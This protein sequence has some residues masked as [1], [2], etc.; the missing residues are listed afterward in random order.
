[1]DLG[2]GLRAAVVRGLRGTAWALVVFDVGAPITDTGRTAGLPLFVLR[3]AAEVLSLEVATL[4]EIGVVGLEAAFSNASW[5][6][7]RFRVSCTLNI[8]SCIEER[9]RAGVPKLFDLLER[10]GLEGVVGDGNDMV[11]AV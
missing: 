5:P 8:S 9:R 7:D 4:S 11:V 3:F 1:M 2:R 10:P 6:S